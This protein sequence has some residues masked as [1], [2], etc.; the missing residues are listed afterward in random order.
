M[1]KIIFLFITVFATVT[2]FAQ[3]SEISVDKNGARIIKGFINK[4]DLFS[5]SSLQ[6][7]TASYKNISLNPL[8]VQFFR[9]GKDSVYILAFGG[10]WCDDTRQILP[11]V[12]AIADAAGFSQERIILLGVDRDKKTV[13]HLSE[14]FN[15]THVPTFIVMKNGRETGRIVEWGKT[16][17]PEKE[18]GELVAASAK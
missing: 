5:D 1:K 14:T 3:T 17:Q 6:W 8:T 7:F 4:P 9:R 12:F 13:Q 18:L 11:K 16:G 15:I 2:S 10:T